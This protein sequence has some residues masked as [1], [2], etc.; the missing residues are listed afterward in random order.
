MEIYIIIINN[1]VIYAY[2]NPK[3]MNRKYNSICDHLERNGYYCSDFT[4]G[5]DVPFYSGFDTNMTLEH[6]ITKNKFVISTRKIH[7]YI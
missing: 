2:G 4:H 7:L 3:A 6:P 1:E 5:E